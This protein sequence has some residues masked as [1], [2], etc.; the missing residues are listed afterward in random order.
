M[1][2]FVLLAMVAALVG[3]AF[4]AWSYGF[5][6]LKLLI[7]RKA[8]TALQEVAI[9]F[10]AIGVAVCIVPA[11]IALAP[12]VK[13]IPSNGRPTPEEVRH[14]VSSISLPGLLATPVALIIFLAL[15]ELISK[16]MWEED[17][18]S[19]GKHRSKRRRR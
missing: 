19:F 6:A 10:F 4:I 3:P 14:A 7:A 1:L 11:F 15:C 13:V 8:I 9:T 16:R 18:A 12:L 5:H 2:Q 17:S